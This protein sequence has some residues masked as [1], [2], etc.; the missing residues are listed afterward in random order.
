M[1]RGEIYYITRPDQ[2]GSLIHAAGRPAIIVSRQVLAQTSPVQQ[3]VFLTTR[4]KDDTP[5]HVRI[6]STGKPS[7]AICEQVDSVPVS[8]IG[9]RCA[10]CTLEEMEAIDAALMWCLGL[11]SAPAEPDAEGDDAGAY[12]YDDATAELA[13]ELV[14]A[15]AELAASERFIQQLLDRLTTGRGA[16]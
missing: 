1:N 2:E 11:P 5:A 3:V 10:V 13:Q 4:E 8:A 15:R 6:N 12:D 9:S 16:R 14:Q 7:T